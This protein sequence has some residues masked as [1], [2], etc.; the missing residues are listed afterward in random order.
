[1]NPTTKIDINNPN[2]LIRYIIFITFFLIL[3]LSILNMLKINV[4]EIETFN[5]NFKSELLYQNKISSVDTITIIKTNLNT[6]K[7][8]NSRYIIVNSF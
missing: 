3:L 7:E 5:S 2:T 1:M 8:Y 6:N 4:I